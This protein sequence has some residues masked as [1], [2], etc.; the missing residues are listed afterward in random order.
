MP[1]FA[2]PKQMVN[3]RLNGVRLLAPV[4]APAKEFAARGR[5]RS[6]GIG[7]ARGRHQG[8]A[9]P[10]RDGA[11]VG[12]APRNEAPHVHHEE[13]DENVEVENVEQIGQEEEV[14]DETTC[15]PLLD[16]VLA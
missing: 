11:P 10:T 12:D 5:G 14:Q 13:I 1:Q 6:R 9:E 8:R 4:N 15:I 7:S 3:T 16:P 2:T